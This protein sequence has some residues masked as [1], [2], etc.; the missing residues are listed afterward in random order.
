MNLISFSFVAS[1]F[2]LLQK[3]VSCL[4]FNALVGE[5]I[6]GSVASFVIFSTVIFG[7]SILVAHPLMHGRDV[8]ETLGRYPVQTD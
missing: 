1:L 5:G 3:I 2:L 6:L 4:D 7:F 8:D